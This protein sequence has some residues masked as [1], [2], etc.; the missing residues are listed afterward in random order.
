MFTW[1]LHES[2]KQPDIVTYVFPVNHLETMGVLYDCF[3][4]GPNS[5]IFAN[6]SCVIRTSNLGWTSLSI[7]TAWRMISSFVLPALW[8][9]GALYANRS[10]CLSCS[11]L[12]VFNLPSCCRIVFVCTLWCRI[13][14]WEFY[15][16]KQRTTNEGRHNGGFSKPSKRVK[17]K[18]VIPTQWLHKLH[19][20]SY[21]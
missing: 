11:S 13:M 7:L 2:P 14:K 6:S 1:F 15:L 5:Q 20:W 12:L 3:F 9:L 17:L 16:M 18:I 4:F 19:A 10:D 21:K 8:S